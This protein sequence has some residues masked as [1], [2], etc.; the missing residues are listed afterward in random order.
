MD[1][2]SIRRGEDGKQTTLGRFPPP[3]EILRIEITVNTGARSIRGH[4]FRYFRSRRSHVVFPP[5][6]VQC[7]M[8]LISRTRLIH[9]PVFHFLFCSTTQ[10]RPAEHQ[11]SEHQSSRR[12]QRRWNRSVGVSAETNKRG[13]RKR[14]A[15]AQ[16]CNEDFGV[17]QR[18]TQ[19]FASK[20]GESTA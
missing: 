14:Y 6:S 2:S 9:P 11:I 20:N 18:K 13:I 1:W 7:L 8:P 15:N 12:R 19:V 17:A 16:I 5:R 3:V 4:N 10:H